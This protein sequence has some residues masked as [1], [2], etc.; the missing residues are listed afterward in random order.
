MDHTQHRWDTSGHPSAAALHEAAHAVLALAAGVQITRAA[1]VQESG[2]AV[3]GTT[4]YGPPWETSIAALAAD[5][6]RFARIRVL[7][8]GKVAERLERRALLPP[9]PPVTIEELIHVPRRHEVV[10]RV[11]CDEWKARKLI[12]RIAPWITARTRPM[13]A[14]EELARLT[15]IVES[16]RAPIERVAWTLE[17]HGR[18]GGPRIVELV[19]DLSTDIQKAMIA[20]PSWA[21]RQVL[22]SL[23]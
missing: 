18:V 3:W 8:V 22:R 16:L 4:T 1:L 7:L 15:S 12:A 23:T 2:G 13:V 14:S 19:G 10:G 6:R 17:V 5:E 11:E 21:T 9:R 20:T